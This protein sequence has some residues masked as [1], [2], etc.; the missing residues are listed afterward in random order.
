MVFMAIVSASFLAHLGVDGH[1]DECHACEIAGH[2][3]AV[4]VPLAALD[5]AE[6]SEDVQAPVEALAVSSESHLSCAPRAPPI[7]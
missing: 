5:S 6:R 7:S 3:V 1:S 2:S 4:T